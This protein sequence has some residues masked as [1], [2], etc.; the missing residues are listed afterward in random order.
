M[1]GNA[2]SGTVSFAPSTP[3]LVDATSKTV[4]GGAPVTAALNPSGAFSVVLPCTDG[5]SPSGWGWTVTENISGGPLRTY[6]V[7]LPH[8]LGT[9]ADIA[10]LTPVASPAVESPYLL[11]SQLGTANGPAQLNGSALLPVAQGGT[12]G[13]TAPLARAGIGAA[14]SAAASDW[15]NAVNAYGADPTGAADSTTAI[16]NALNAAAQSASS[17]AGSPSVVYLPAGQYLVS[18]PLVPKTG[19]R[20]CGDGPYATGIT[21]TASSIFNCAPGSLVD[22]FELD[23]LSLQCTGHD[24]FTGA[25]VARWYVHDCRFTQNSAG[26]SIWGAPA[27]ALMIECT[28]ERNQE[29]AHGAT[30]TVPAWNIQ[31][32]SNSMQANANT[33]RDCVAFNADGDATQYWYYIAATAAGVVNQANRFENLTFENPL[34]GMIRLDSHQQGHIDGC[35]A[36]DLSGTIGN[37]LIN[38]GYNA[39]SAAASIGTVITHSGTIGISGYAYG[40]GASTIQLDAHSSGTVIITPQRNPV[41]D[42]GNSGSV[43]LLGLPATYTLNN[44]GGATFG[45]VDG[46]VPPAENFPQPDDMGFAAVNFDPAIASSTAQLVAGTI[47]MHQLVVRRTVTVSK[48]WLSV[49]TGASGVTANQNFAA[50]VNSSGTIVASSAAG[51]MDTVITSSG[52]QPVSFTGSVTLTPGTYY[53]AVLVNAST[54]P[55]LNRSAAS[56]QAAAGHYGGANSNLRWAVNGTAQTALPGS[57]TLSAN[58]ASG[59]LAVNAAVQ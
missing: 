4:F 39:T 10:T 43:T 23:H 20:M 41:L 9:T 46:A 2:R 47:Y 57:F 34:G 22:R 58:N 48:A 16:Q 19:V 42:L 26:N 6:Q 8:T 13:G 18:S 55:V 7:L 51:A 45:A 31:S 30:R 38:V 24:I 32:Q 52:W 3:L 29:L 44:A 49:S 37:S 56:P 11:A 35:M 36:W 33:W 53:L 28:F 50:L 40:A 1:A 14:N 15:T 27:V 12:G 5:L 21:A 17:F 59:A 25:D 54:M